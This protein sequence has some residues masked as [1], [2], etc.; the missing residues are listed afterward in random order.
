M[1]GRLRPEA[2]ATVAEEPLADEPSAEEPLA[3]EP[4]AEAPEP[5]PVEEPEQEY[6]IWSNF[7]LPSSDAVA[8]LAAADSDIERIVYGTRGRLVHKW[9]HYLPIYDAHFSKFRGTDFRML[10]IG[11]FKGGSLELWRS[12]FGDKATIVG[13]DIDPTCADVVDPPNIVRIGSQDDPEFLRAVNEEFGPFDLVLDDGS[14]FGRHQ[15]TSFDVLFPLLKSGG[16]YVIEDLHTSYWRSFEGGYRQP[17]TAI[18]LVK[19]VIDDMHSWYHGHDTTT[20]ARDS[21]VGIHVYD[22]MTVMDKGVKEPP[23]N[24]KVH[25]G[26]G[27]GE[28]PA[29]AATP[30]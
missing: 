9:L 11:V 17:G 20:P 30:E 18:E 28:P 16:H 25:A 3:E 21:I 5:E 19:D 27:Y 10:E 12:Y 29:S 15:L 6:E 7:Q 23:R 14:H 26:A 4:V 13:V 2:S 8:L 1:T 24:I 22:S